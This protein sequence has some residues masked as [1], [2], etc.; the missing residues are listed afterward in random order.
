MN[1]GVGKEREN[2]EIVA[3]DE[4][5]EDMIALLAETWLFLAGWMTAELPIVAEWEG[6]TGA[7]A[8]LDARKLAWSGAQSWHRAR[9]VDSR[10]FSGHLD[11]SSHP[12]GPDNG[13]PSR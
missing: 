4:G 12:V 1:Y 6:P 3:D 8:W 7:A 5:G 10:T 11:R 13:Q 9:S 2:K